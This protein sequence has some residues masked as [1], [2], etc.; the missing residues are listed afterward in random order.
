MR[1]CSLHTTAFASSS[2]SSKCFDCQP[3][4][5]RPRGP[6]APSRSIP[7]PWQ[8]A[9]VRWHAVLDGARAHVQQIADIWS[10]GTTL[11]LA[12][13]RAHRDALPHQVLLQTACR[14][15]PT[16]DRIQAIT[17]RVL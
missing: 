12:Q 14:M 6:R 8:A 7:L 13:G 11:E 4:A 17:L 2:P 9:S 1:P 16:L 15:P 10:V 5:C 3:L